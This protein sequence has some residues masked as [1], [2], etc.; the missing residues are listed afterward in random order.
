V[1]DKGDVSLMIDRTVDGNENS[2]DRLHAAPAA[3][4]ETEG[5]AQPH[6]AAYVKDV[7]GCLMVP[8]LLTIRTF[9]PDT[10]KKNVC[11]KAVDI[12]LAI[13]NKALI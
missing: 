8:E 6:R 3:E 1:E 7:M 9:L 4:G 5:V 12:V 13:D 2:D 11:A 10:F